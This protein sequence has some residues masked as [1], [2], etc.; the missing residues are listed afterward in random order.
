[1]QIGRLARRIAAS[2]CIAGACASALA[3]GLEAPADWRKESFT[4]PLPYAPSLPYEGTEEVRFSPQWARFE[5]PDGFT[6]AVLWDIKPTAMEGLALER[7]LSVYFD[8]LMNNVAIGRKLDAMVPQTQ[9]ALHPLAPPESWS[10]AYAGTIHTWNGFAKAEP[11]VLNAEIAYRA[12]GER[13][14]VLFGL[15]KAARSAPSWQALRGI[16]S[17]TRCPG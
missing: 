8:G 2:C 10:G 12:C 4:F 11:L 13:M 7:A 15:S 3:A 17:A 6:Y 16:R 9:V 1:M 14:Q 5:A